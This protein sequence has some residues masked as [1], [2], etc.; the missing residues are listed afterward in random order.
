MLGGQSLALGGEAEREAFAARFS[1]E[2]SYGTEERF[3]RR[4]EAPPPSVREVSMPELLL[5]SSF[6][7][8][9]A[10]NRQKNAR[11]SVW[12]RGAKSR[13]D[14][15]EDAVSIDGEVVT[16]TLGLD[17]EWERWI[18]GMALSRS[19]GDGS[20]RQG[21]G[22][23]SGCGGDV[24]SVIT[25]FYPFVRYDV[26]ER[27]SVWGILGHG[28]GE[29]TLTP[30]GGADIEANTVMQMAAFGGRGVVLG[31]SNPLGVELAVRSDA[32][33][34]SARSNSGGAGGL[35]DGETD[36]SRLRLLLEGAR[37]YRFG[38]GGVLEPTLE[39]G[40][41]F[42][43]G[44]ADEGSGLEVGGGLRYRRPAIGLTLEVSARGLLS[45]EV[46]DYEE[47]GVSGSMRVEPGED[48]RGLSVRL[49]SAWGAV[50]GG[51]ERLWE[52]RFGGFG[53]GSFEAD[54]RFDAEVS[55]GLDAPRGLLTP[56]TGVAVS[57]NAETWR[58]GARWQIGAMTTLDL[59]ASLKESASDR[60]RQGA[61]LLQGARRW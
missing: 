42:D 57:E 22:C 19:Q 15:R 39:F 33:F 38:A 13:F 48:G 18:F 45:H 20:F 35:L 14:A 23:A 12:G 30:G 1:E 49:G 25:G 32:L 6:H 59:E 26:S 56:Y 11:W 17:Y 21:A 10:K 16:A 50:S 34:V 4:E 2:Y 29:M 52:Q 24:K 31:A 28:Q 44:D 46:R 3:L 5:E 60:E 7:L 47:W 37:S 27:L 41:R 54:S 36:T 55:Y 61:I 51:A 53:A 43:G 40:F 9:S 58:A 8:A